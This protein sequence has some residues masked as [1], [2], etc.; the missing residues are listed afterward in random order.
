MATPPSSYCSGWTP[1]ITAVF[2]QYG[3]QYPSHFIAMLSAS[4]TH[5]CA[6]RLELQPVMSPSCSLRNE[7]SF[8][9]PS[10]HFAMAFQCAH[11]LQDQR[12]STTF[13]KV[14]SLT[15]LQLDVLGV[16]GTRRS[17]LYLV[18]VRTSRSYT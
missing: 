17:I 14:V 2:T 11:A 13:S 8:A 15:H 9:S 16:L 5:L 4:S 1:P 3:Q 12:T 18:R 10:K 6:P 7:T